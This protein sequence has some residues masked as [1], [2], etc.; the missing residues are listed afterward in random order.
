MINLT[1]DIVSYTIQCLLFY[2]YILAMSQIVQNTK[3]ITKNKILMFL[4]ALLM[5]ISGILLKGRFPINTIIILFILFSFLFFILKLKKSKAAI[6][7]ILLS[8]SM[9]IFEIFIVLIFSVIFNKTS[10]EMSKIPLICFAIS[11][12]CSILLLLTTLIFNKSVV[13]KQKLRDFFYLFNK[14]YLKIVIYIFLFTIIPQAVL[15][16]LNKYNYDPIFL[17]FNFISL[18]AI[19][20]FLFW[21]ISN[22]LEKEKIQEQVKTLEM[23]N[24]TLGGMVDGVRT[25]KHD[26]NNIFQ[27]INGY[28]C[29]KQYDELEQYIL[30]VMKECNIVNTLSIINKNVFDDPANY[31]VIGSKYFIATESNITMDLD[32]TVSFKDINFPMAE[33]SRIFGILLDNAI[34][35]TSK[36]ENKYIRLEI[37]YVSRKNA[38]IIRILNTF[39]KSL[40]IDLNS[41]YHKGYSSKKIKSGLG[42]WQA[43]K[44]IS[45]Y[46]HSQMY[47]T[48]EN[49]K[50]V[51]NIIIE[52]T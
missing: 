9:I 45:R 40:K 50:F 5:T 23:D 29:S 20:I 25:I 41:L 10:L 21:Y 14:R 51:Q 31:G 7:T 52:N 30:K 8:I 22:F 18:F 42:L 13:N 33:L 26:F 48:I 36:C 38:T 32:V 4:C 44:I 24:K 6:I 39:D 49:D 34:E 28:I 16:L 11:I 12:S 1:L 27:A 2:Y 19:S 15:I 47:T 46:K 35:A 43:S 17:T 37:K 3:Y